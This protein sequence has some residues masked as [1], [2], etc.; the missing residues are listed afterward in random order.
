[1][2]S[3]IICYFSVGIGVLRLNAYLLTPPAELRWP[4]LRHGLKG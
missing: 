3:S 2:P 1:M 4:V